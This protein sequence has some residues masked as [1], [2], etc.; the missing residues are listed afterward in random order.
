M[1][2]IVTVAVK[3]CARGLAP[4]RGESTFPIVALTDRET[5]A[6]ETFFPIAPRLREELLLN[7]PARLL[8]GEPL[9]P[10]LHPDPIGLLKIDVRIP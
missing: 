9:A 5:Q 8:Q 4:T 6:L 10:N 7:L 2:T 3:N 1:T